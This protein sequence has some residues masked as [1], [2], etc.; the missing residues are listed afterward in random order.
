MTPRAFEAVG[1]AVCDAVLDYCAG[2]EASTTVT[3][4]ALPFTFT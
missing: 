4:A 3:A 1:R 2:P